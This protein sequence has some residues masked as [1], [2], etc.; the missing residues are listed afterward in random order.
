MSRCIAIERDGVRLACREFGGTGS[1][2]LLLHGLAGYADEWSQTARWLTQRH[3]V[4]AFDAHGHGRSERVP[5]DVSPAAHVADTAY[6]IEQLGL[7]GCAVIGHSMGGLTALLLAAAHPTLLRALIVAEAMPAAP[8]EAGVEEVE[9]SLAGWPVPFQSQPSAIEFFGGPSNAA[10][11]WAN[12]LEQREDGWW[13]QFDLP[14]MIRTLREAP[15]GP[16]WQEWERVS[17]PTLIVRGSKGTLTS[18]DAH[19][20]AERLPTSR[21][22]EIAEAGHD[23]HL[24]RPAD[25]QRTVEE[26]LTSL[27]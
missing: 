5:N 22:A 18:S 23:V 27:E 4:Y 16:Y 13:P 14:V 11:A 26:F 6:V 2:I 8:D 15:P 20:M 3:R 10:D 24:D 1:P 7:T 25:W 9:R 19:R 12:S 17:C 21:L